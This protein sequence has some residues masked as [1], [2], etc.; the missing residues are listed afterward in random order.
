MT[1]QCENYMLQLNWKVFRTILFFNT[2]FKKKFKLSF[3]PVD[4]FKN[5]WVFFLHAL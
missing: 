5:L 1:T 2:V 3:A 4:P